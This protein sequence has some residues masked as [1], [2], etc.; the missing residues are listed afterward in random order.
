MW[1]PRDQ[2]AFSEVG[3]KTKFWCKLGLCRSW[4]QNETRL[5]VGEE[6]LDV[7]K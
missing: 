2:C 3:C 5:G 4:K 7:M 1:M 6:R